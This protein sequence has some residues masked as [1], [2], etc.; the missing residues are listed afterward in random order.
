MKKT[1]SLLLVLVL[2]MTALLSIAG[3]SS[4]SITTTSTTISTT[5][6]ESS[7][8]KATEDK[9]YKFAVS[10]MTFNNP[11]WVYEINTLK[12]AIE[13]NGDTLAIY[14]AQLDQT[15]QISQIED[16]ISSGVDLIFISPYDMKGIK[17]ALEAAKKAGIPVV[18]IDTSVFDQDLVATEVISDNYLAGVQCGENL[19]K[20]IGEKGEIGIIDL[21]VN[22]VVQERVKGFMSVIDKYPEIKVV[23]KL[24]GNGSVEAALPLM[25]TMLQANPNI[26]GVF[27]IN[28]P[29]SLGAIAA[30]ESAGKIKDV[31]VV[32]VDGAKDACTSIREGKMLGTSAQFPNRIAETCAEQAYKIL[33]GETVEHTIVIPVEWINKDNVDQYEAY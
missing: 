21:S 27:G 20:A 7:T 23:S 6:T 26:K 28:D 11:F 30:L 15:K 8:T 13:A 19:V 3:C 24:D 5:K 25:E 31:F 32:S 14:D 17:P 29:T 22:V 4:T 1:I 18:N 12:A 2:A 10:I 9:K 16:A 33:N